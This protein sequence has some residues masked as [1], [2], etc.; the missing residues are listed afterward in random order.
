MTKPRTVIDALIDK[1]DLRCTRCNAAMGGCDCWTKCD[2]GWSFE[3]G[4]A[5]RNPMHGGKPGPLK[6]IAFGRGRL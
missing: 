5:C 3:K 1:A 2:C 6:S 4:T